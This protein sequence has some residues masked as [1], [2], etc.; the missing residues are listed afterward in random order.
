MKATPGITHTH[1][2]NDGTFTAE[3]SIKLQDNFANP[4][5]TTNIS[6]VLLSEVYF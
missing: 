1:Q 4:M 3:F 2:G 6:L 5:L